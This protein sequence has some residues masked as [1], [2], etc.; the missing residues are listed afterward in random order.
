LRPA[1]GEMRWPGC[2]FALRS[3]G[4]AQLI[5]ERREGGRATQKRVSHCTVAEGPRAAK[6]PETNGWQSHPVCRHGRKLGNLEE[7]RSRGGAAHQERWD[8]RCCLLGGSHAF[9]V[10]TD[11]LWQGGSPAVPGVSVGCPTPPSSSR[12][13]VSGCALP[14]LPIVSPGQD[15]A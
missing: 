4:L 1:A 3:A 11:A 5:I 8:A 12:G 14:L 7:G 15:T 13:I 9:R 10:Q 2:R 6:P